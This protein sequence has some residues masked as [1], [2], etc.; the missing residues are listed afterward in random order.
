MAE[1]QHEQADSDE[2]LR[3]FRLAQAALPSSAT[4]AVANRRPRDFR[5]NVKLAFM[6]M[7]CELKRSPPFE[8]R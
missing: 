3:R 7:P 6:K 8:K 5:Q 4:I 2:A 1:L